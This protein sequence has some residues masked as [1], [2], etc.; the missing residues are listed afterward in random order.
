MFRRC[1]RPNPRTLAVVLKCDIKGAPSPAGLA[2]ECTFIASQAAQR[3]VLAKSWSSANFSRLCI[4]S[5][6][7]GVGFSF[8][9]VW[10]VPFNAI[11]DKRLNALDASKP[12]MDI[13]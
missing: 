7:L 4:E 8:S 2:G 1:I 11:G 12:S 10:S 9:T 6:W 3:A 5:D 13:R